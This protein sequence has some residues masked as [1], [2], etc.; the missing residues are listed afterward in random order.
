[1]TE[2]TKISPMRKSLAQVENDFLHHHGVSLS[3][4]AGDPTTSEDGQRQGILLHREAIGT[5]TS[6]YTNLTSHSIY[7][8]NYAVFYKSHMLNALS[9][10]AVDRLP[11]GLAQGPATRKHGA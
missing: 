9:L 7:R 8:T 5:L 10:P 1:M 3:T 4:Q 11:V 6:C 2:T